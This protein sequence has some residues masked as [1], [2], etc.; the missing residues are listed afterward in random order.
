LR[1]Y[2]IN[3]EHRARGKIFLSKFYPRTKRDIISWR[4]FKGYEAKNRRRL[5]KPVR[6]ADF[7]R[8]PLKAPE[9]QLRKKVAKFR[10]PNSRQRVFEQ[11]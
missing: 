11:I 6:Q 4:D 3:F 8:V 10:T 5:D 2:F 9:K 7:S 1:V